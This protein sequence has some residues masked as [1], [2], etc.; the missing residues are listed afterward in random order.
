MKLRRLIKTDAPFM[1]EWMHDKNVTQNLQANFAE[2]QLTDCI[3]FIEHSRNDIENEHFAIVDEK[4]EYMGT[5]SLKN[6][7]RSFMSAE[8]AISIRS[9][10]MG[11]GLSR[12]GMAQIIQ[13]GLDELGLK[14]IYWCVS[15]DNKRAVRFYD[16]NGYK[17]VACP[18]K[19]V[20]GYTADQMYYF[21]WYEVLNT[22]NAS[23]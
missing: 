10:A 2:K 22:E 16:K 13:Y 19:E 8:F 11:R 18:P 9:C 23:K 7:N 21:I 3:S 4:D 20:N 1:L 17:R 12:Y 15:P 6:I 5:V 14:K